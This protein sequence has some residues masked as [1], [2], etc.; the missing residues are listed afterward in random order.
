MALNDTMRGVAWEGISFEMPT[1]SLPVPTTLCEADALI[2]IT[3]S[4]ICGSDLQIY[5]GLYGSPEVPWTMGHEGMG[6]VLEVGEAVAHVEVGDYVVIPGGTDSGHLEMGVIEMGIS[7]GLGQTWGDDDG[8]GCQEGPILTASVPTEYIRVPFAD[9]RLIPISSDVGRVGNN[10]NNNTNN[11]T[12]SGARDLDYLFLSDIFPTGWAA[13]DFARFEPGDTVAV[14]SAGPVGLLSAHSAIIRAAS[15]VYVVDYVQSPLDLA[16]SIVAIPINFVDTDPVE[17]I[18]RYEPNGGVIRS[19]EC[20]AAEAFNRD[21][22]I[23]QDIIIGQM[24]AVTRGGGGIGQ[25]VVTSAFPDSPGTPRASTISPNITFPLASFHDK[26]LSFTSRGMDHKSYAPMLSDLISTR[27]ARP[28]FII[29]RDIGIEDTPEYYE[30]FERR[31]DI[32]IVI[33]F[34]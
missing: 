13:L 16:E 30:R 22:E 2:R 18:L 29:D 19:V 26:R 10:T 24:I 17:E 12:S 34:P 8:S 33:R 3:A 5:R 15:K 20:V 25:V 27:K 31:E 23:E 11:N 1:R 14:F 9:M 4:A 21:L 7:F 32:K 28:S 6:Y